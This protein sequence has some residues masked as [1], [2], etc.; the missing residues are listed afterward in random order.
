MGFW[1][2]VASAGRYASNLL[3]TDNH[4]N[5]SPLNFYRPDDLPDAQ[6]TVSEHSRQLDSPWHT[7]RQISRSGGSLQR[8]VEMPLVVRRVTRQRPGT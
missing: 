7:Y 1:D 4:T 2:A 5:T 6:P 3:Q 8:C